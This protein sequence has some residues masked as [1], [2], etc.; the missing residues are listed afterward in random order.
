MEKDNSSY[1]STYLLFDAMTFYQKL[2]YQMIDVP[3]LVD[4]DAVKATIPPNIECLMHNQMYY[5]GSAEQSFIHMYKNNMLKDGKY[6]AMTPCHRFEMNENNLHFQIFLKLELIDIGTVDSSILNDATKFFSK[7]IAEITIEKT[8]SGTDLL[9][10]GIE[11]GSYGTR[12]FHNHVPY[13][14]GTGIAE[15]RTSFVRKINNG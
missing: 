7:H 12:Y 9:S 2:G 4:K 10:N 5:V 13:V 3:M 14:Y 1:I 8:N 11:L 15:P 6:M